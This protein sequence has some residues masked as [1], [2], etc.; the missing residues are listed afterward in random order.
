MVDELETIGL[1]K[2]YTYLRICVI[3]SQQDG[4]QDRVK[5]VVYQKRVGRGSHNMLLIDNTLNI[6]DQNKREA[7]PQS[8]VSNWLSQK[9]LSFKETVSILMAVGMESGT[10]NEGRSIKL[11]ADMDNSTHFVWERQSKRK[12]RLT[13]TGGKLYI[14]SNRHTHRYERTAE[15]YK[16]SNDKIKEILD[17]VNKDLHHGTLQDILQIGTLAGRVPNCPDTMMELCLA[18]GAI[19]F[20]LRVTLFSTEGD[21]KSNIVIFDNL[22][23]ISSSR[24]TINNYCLKIAAHKK[25]LHGDRLLK[26]DGTYIAADKGSGILCKEAS[27]WDQVEDSITSLLLDFGTAGNKAQDSGKAIKMQ[28]INIC[29]MVVR[30]NLEVIVLIMEADLWKKKWQRLL[31]RND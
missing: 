17:A 22:T 8:F 2:K 23:A 26:S 5:G 4:I 20:A 9:A 14:I 16:S 19:S 15:T 28:L 11:D 18:Q 10:P 31:S 6:N 29:L 30:S 12:E 1:V 25:V 24:T 7:E 27:F 21:K 3:H 13:C